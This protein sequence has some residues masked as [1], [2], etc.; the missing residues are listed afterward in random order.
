MALFLRETTFCCF[1]K[2]R[3]STHRL[4][5]IPRLVV[6]VDMPYI[7]LITEID[8][9]PATYAYTVCTCRSVIENGPIVAPADVMDARAM[10]LLVHDSCLTDIGN[11]NISSPSAE[12]AYCKSLLPSYPIMPLWPRFPESTPAPP[13]RPPISRYVHIRPRPAQSTPGATTLPTP[14]APTPRSAP[15]PRR[16]LTDEERRRIC[17]YH[18]DHKEAKQTDIGGKFWARASA[19]RSAYSFGT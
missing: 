8:T 6:S 5:Q 1:S 2:L 9:L 16:T 13:P 19:N 11:H 10:S 17:Q 15:T 4:P 3:Q 14:E 12:A 7:F 18:E